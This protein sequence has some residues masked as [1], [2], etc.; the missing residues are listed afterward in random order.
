MISRQ[1]KPRSPK[2][3]EAAPRSFLQRY[4]VIIIAVTLFIVIDMGVLALN[5]YNS[6][7]ILISNDPQPPESSAADEVCRGRPRRAVA[8]GVF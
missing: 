4:R 7:Q 3:G 8:C 5:F 2:A 6:F 1:K